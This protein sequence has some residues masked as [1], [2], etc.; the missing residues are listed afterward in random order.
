MTLRCSMCGATYADSARYCTR[1]G[2]RLLGPGDV[3]VAVA[4]ETPLAT[5]VMTP[6]ELASLSGKTLRFTKVKDNCAGRPE[7]L[8]TSSWSKIR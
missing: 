2:T 6:G 3:V 7:V 1:D 8:T 5:P 4:V